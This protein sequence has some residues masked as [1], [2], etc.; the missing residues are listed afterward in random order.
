ML[1]FNP[2]VWLHWAGEIFTTGSIVRGS[3]LAA[4]VLLFL[5]VAGGMALSMQLLS[6]RQRTVFL[7]YH[8]LISVAA[9]LMLV[10]HSLAFFLGKYEFLSWQDVLIPFWTKRHTAEI[11]VGIIATYMMAALIFSSFRSVMKAIRFDNWR[12]IHFF[13]FPCYWMAL[14]HSVALAKSSNEL[15]LSYVYPATAS[16]VAA[17]TLLRIWKLIERRFLADESAAG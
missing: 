3:G 16:L 17:L 8:R 5:I 11:A 10:V 12:L 15:F 7:E 1:I 14:Y 9:V 2:L 13:A 6:P 4:Y